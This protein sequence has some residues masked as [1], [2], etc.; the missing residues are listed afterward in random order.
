MNSAIL[1]DHSYFISGAYYFVDVNLTLKDQDLRGGAIDTTTTPPET[2][3]NTTASPCDGVKDTDVPGG[4]LN[5]TGV[6]VILGG[7]S[8]LHANNP[9]GKLELFARKGGA[10]SEGTQGVSVMTV[11]NTAA[12]IAAGWLPSTLSTAGSSDSSLQVDGN[13]GVVLGVHGMVYTPNAK[14]ELF[15]TNGGAATLQ[16]GA[17][18]ARIFIQGSAVAKNLAVSIPGGTGVRRTVITAT[19]KGVGRDVIATAVVTI[20]AA[21]ARTV[22]IESWRSS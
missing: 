13:P 14:V 10:A 5:G 20:G 16:G 3:V 21:P 22:T 6:K 15:A 12:V 4:V 11:P 19:A 7:S 17:V 8:S 9:D 18:V 1:G 2:A